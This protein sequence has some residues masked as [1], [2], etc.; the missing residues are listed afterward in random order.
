[1]LS[2]GKLKRELAA[3]ISERNTLMQQLGL[4]RG[5]PALLDQL[6]QIVL[7]ICRVLPQFED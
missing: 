6:T 1:M 4:Q 3:L 5:K 2:E 7:K